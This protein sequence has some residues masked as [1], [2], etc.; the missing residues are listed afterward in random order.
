MAISSA[1]SLGLRLISIDWT[2]FNKLETPHLVLGFVWQACRLY[3][4]KGIDL[5]HCNE[6][7]RLLKDG[8]DLGVF[9][10][11]KPEEILIRWINYH[12]RQ[13]GQDR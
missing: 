8:E 3:L 1:K 9:K 13:A 6:L 12:L 7:F 5:A 4:T 10:K 11:M 2:S